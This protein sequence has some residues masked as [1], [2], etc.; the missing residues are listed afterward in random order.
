IYTSPMERARETAQTV[1]V[2]CDA[3][4]RV[5]DDLTEIDFGE[6]TGRTFEELATMS[7]WQRFNE[8]R[9][10]AAVPGGERA[11]DA[12]RRIVR[13]L[14]TLAERHWGE[15]IA[16][17]THADMIRY[18]VLHY[19]RTSL[20]LLHEVDI[21]PA[22]V[23]TVVVSASDAQV[24]SVNETIDARDETGQPGRRIQQSS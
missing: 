4:V 21:D 18:A 5:R 9:S 19:T 24:I 17:M 2:H 15:R 8:A 14:S 10:V 3:P 7:Q 20:D 1:S 22:S 23:T 13:A 11:V 16:V 12:Q 6:W